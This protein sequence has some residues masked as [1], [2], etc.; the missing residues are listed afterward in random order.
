[1]TPEGYSR[2]ESRLLGRSGGR[3]AGARTRPAARR[4]ATARERSG[5]EPPQDLLRQTPGGWTPMPGPGARAP[6]RLTERAHRVLDVL[7]WTV[8]AVTCG[9]L[10]LVLAAWFGVGR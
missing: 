8:W 9:L 3:S 6:F 2:A 1:M 7:A 5:V 4:R 10:A